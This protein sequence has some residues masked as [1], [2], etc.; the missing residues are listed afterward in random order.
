MPFAEPEKAGGPYAAELVNHLL[1]VWA[2]DYLDDVPSKFSRAGGQSDV[3][4][5]DL[6]DLD[7]IDEFTGEPG[8]LSRGAWWRPG[9][10]IGS[11]K[12]RLGSKDPVLAWMRLGVA[13]TGF[14]A[15][16]ELVSAT[17]DPSARARATAWLDANPD[18]QPT[19]FDLPRSRGVSQ[20]AA[21]P[22]QAENPNPQPEVE[23]QR[24]RSDLERMAQ[25]AQRGAERLPEPRP[26]RFPY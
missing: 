5:V 22:A 13:S 26:E 21:P 2:V 4:V 18:F 23:S 14:N 16:Y 8:Q 1:M 9:R 11:L 3:I 15:P 7:V 20:A 24:I 19:G 17:G 10:L 6:V 12:R 25:Q